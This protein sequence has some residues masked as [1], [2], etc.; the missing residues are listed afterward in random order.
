MQ[1]IDPCA[2]CLPFE[3]HNRVHNLTFDS[4]IL[5]V[6]LELPKFQLKREQI[7]N[8]LDSWLYFLC[9]AENLDENSLPETICKPE[10]CRALEELLMLS[11]DDLEREKYAARLRVL[12]DERSRLVSAHDE[13]LEQGLRT[14]QL[15]GIIGICEK[16]LDIEP[17]SAEKLK[18]L[19]MTELENYA[20]EL[21]K[22]V[23][24]G[25]L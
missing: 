17:S 20:R 3:L 5:I 9:N 16:F 1:K 11:Q 19:S 10:I 22:K 23:M 2:Y 4:D 21:E 7:S 8:P 6:V 13:G 14:G 18:G 15:I 24:S 12:M 25:K